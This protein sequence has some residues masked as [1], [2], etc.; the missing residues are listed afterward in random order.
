[1]KRVEFIKQVEEKR[2]LPVYLFLGE[3]TLFQ[4]ELFRRAVAGLLT[5]EEEQ[6]NLMRV[7]A[8]DLEPETL[9]SN[10][11]T[12]PFFGPNRII[13]L[14]ELEKA[15]NGLE[16]AIIKGLG[17]LANG[18]YLFIAAAKLDGRKKLH[19]ELQKRI[20]V[21]DCN[22]VTAN[23]MPAWVKQ[24]AGEL[25]LKLTGEQIRVIAGRLGVDLRR[26]RTELEKMRTFAGAAGKLSD[27]ELDD[28]LPVEPEPNIFGLIDAVAERNPRL[29]LPRLQ[30]LL[31]A[32]EPELKIL[33]TLARQF[34]NV[35]AANEARSQGIGSK[36]LAAMLGINPFVAEKSF[37]QSGR[38]T[39]RELQQVIRRLLMAD[40]RIKSGQRE[41][42]LELEL[43][44]VEICSRL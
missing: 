25:G 17:R 24:Y 26:L 9:I 35:V 5:A 20:T 32:G 11:E 23:E 7:S 4:E 30:E 31:D 44:V 6:F 3:E 29:G 1:M 39:L 19:Q 36:A 12:A 18:V 15:K 40:Y 37:V 42:R 2:L 8:A 28:L 21:V 10:L 38:F 33:A 14:V 43:A 27:A 41:P 34:R 13:H 22:K 16:E